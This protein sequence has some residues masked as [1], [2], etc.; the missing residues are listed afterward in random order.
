MDDGMYEVLLVKN[1]TNA[2]ESQQMLGALVSQNYE[3]EFVRM[4]KA[5]RIRFES[6]EAIS[7]TIDGEYGG[8][9]R[10]TLI[11]NNARAITLMT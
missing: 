4:L 8:S 9:A 2:I 1:P 7:W 5:A 3:G 11:V 6:D 10:D